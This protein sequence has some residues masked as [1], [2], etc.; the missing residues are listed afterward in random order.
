V[1]QQRRPEEFPDIGQLNQREQAD[2]LEVDLLGAQHAGTRLIR[3]YSGRPE[4]KPVKTQMS[5]LRVKI[6]RQREEFFRHTGITILGGA[7]LPEKMLQKQFCCGNTAQMSA[8]SD[9]P[10]CVKM[11]GHDHFYPKKPCLKSA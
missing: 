9:A 7:T 6:A 2:H 1:I 11:A 10:G 4:L 3:K 8:L 5:I